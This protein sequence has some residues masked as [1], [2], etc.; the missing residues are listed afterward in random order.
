MVNLISIITTIIIITITVI[1]TI[2]F[3]IAATS[4]GSI[5]GLFGTTV[6]MASFLGSWGTIIAASHISYSSMA[7]IMACCLPS[8]QINQLV[9]LSSILVMGRFSFAP[10]APLSYKYE[11]D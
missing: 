1:V 8:D 10:S 4:I 5:G 3:I 6:I 11:L 2:A 9:L 7:I